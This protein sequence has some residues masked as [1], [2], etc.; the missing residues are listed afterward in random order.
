M[1][2]S[3]TPTPKR[4]RGPIKRKTNTLQ[5]AALLKVLL[6]C[7]GHTPRSKEQIAKITGLTNTTVCRWINLLHGKSGEIKNLVYI[8]EWTRVGERQYPLALW[9]LGYGMF[10]ALKPPRRANKEYSAAWRK[11]QRNTPIVTTTEKGM[12][13]VAR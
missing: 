9:R 12:K 6:G 13:H 1:L 3:D 2:I 8:A 5:N 10:D 4:S 11:R 7:I